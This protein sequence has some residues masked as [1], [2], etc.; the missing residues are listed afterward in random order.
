MGVPNPFFDPFFDPGILFLIAGSK[1]GVWKPNYFR[2]PHSRENFLFVGYRIPFQKQE[3]AQKNGRHTI[4]CNEPALAYCD[5]CISL[6]AAKSL[7]DHQG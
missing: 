4:V 6:S 5:S 2:S 1:K 7:E 3:S